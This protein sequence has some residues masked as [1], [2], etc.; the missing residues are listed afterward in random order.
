MDS[1]ATFPVRDAVMAQTVN[2]QASAAQQAPH[3]AMIIAHRTFQ[4]P[5]FP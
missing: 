4:T 5:K 1:E 2:A 3:Q